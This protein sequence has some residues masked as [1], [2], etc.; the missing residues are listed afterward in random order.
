[1]KS[2]F[3]II[4]TLVLA[5]SAVLITSACTK[6]A[7]T[8]EQVPSAPPAAEN[9]T[10]NLVVARVNGVELTMDAFVRM[11]NI[12]PAKVPATPAETLEERKARALDSLVLLELAYQRAHKLGLNAEPPSIAIGM[13]NFKN[14]IGSEQEYREY[15]AQQHMT[16]EDIRSQ[17][18]RGLTIERIYTAEVIEKVTVPE[19][20]LKKQFAKD[21][22]YLIRPEKVKIIDVHLFKDEGKNSQK[23]A[24]DLIKKI[25]ADPKQDPMKL[26]L[27]G[28]FTVQRTT[29]RPD[30]NKELYDEARKLKPEELSGAIK[31]TNGIHIIKL[32]SYDSERPLTYDEAKPLMEEK[33]KGPA[34]EKLTHEWEQELKKGAK[35]ELFLDNPQ[36]KEI[37]TP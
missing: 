30:K 26:L 22:Q 13:D 29:L 28:T 14:S 36:R 35:I 37:K 4:G 3:R 20:D 2:V 7:P 6:H 10:K 1:M 8:A 34:Q 24:Q 12:L 25:K 27:D 18:E 11:M 32:E 5:V 19:E 21:T 9:E 31:T 17:I 16:E 23:K 15:L 33:L